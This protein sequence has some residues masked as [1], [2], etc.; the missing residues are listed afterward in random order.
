MGSVQD[1][2][3]LFYVWC[4]SRELG[5]G[6]SSGFSCVTPVVGI[7]YLWLKYWRASGASHHPAFM[8]N[9]PTVSHAFLALPTQWIKSSS[10]EWRRGVSS[11]FHLIVL[12]LVW[13][14][15]IWRQGEFKILLC[16]ASGR[17]LLI[18]QSRIQK[19]TFEF[20][21]FL[22]GPGDGKIFLRSSASC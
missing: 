2:I 10:R 22:R 13:I 17:N 19:E 15:R 1:I 6:R 8:G 14:K 11:R 9:C 5:G 3:L 16:N 18:R 12:C 4:E 20:K 21:I 7:L